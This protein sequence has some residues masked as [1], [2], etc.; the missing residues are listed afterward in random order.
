LG[1]WLHLLVHNALSWALGSSVEEEVRAMT[2][3]TVF[4]RL[5]GHSALTCIAD[6]QMTMWV[7]ALAGATDRRRQGAL[8][9]ALNRR[10]LR[11]RGAKVVIRVR[12]TASGKA[13]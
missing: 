4:E 11:C 12:E 6:G 5:L 1:K 7:D 10:E 8:A 9:E 13:L 3:T 2:P